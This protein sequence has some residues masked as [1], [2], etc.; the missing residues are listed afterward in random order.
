M[1]HQ[2]RGVMGALVFIMISFHLGVL[3]VGLQAAV[4]VRLMRR[5]HQE[6]VGQVEA[7]LDGSRLE[8]TRLQLE[9]VESRGWVDLE[10]R[11]CLVDLSVED[12]ALEPFCDLLFE[13]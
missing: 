11:L 1:E 3:R 7:V 12:Q 13:Q 4:A 2:A 6:Q 8:L 10:S 5:E 9:N